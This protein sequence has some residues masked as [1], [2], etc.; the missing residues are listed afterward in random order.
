MLAA[1]MPFFLNI[2]RLPGKHQR[3]WLFQNCKAFPYKRF[4]KL[5]ATSLVTLP[6]LIMPKNV[7]RW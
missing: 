1:W 6:L 7:I 4:G 2:Q 3:F 5:G